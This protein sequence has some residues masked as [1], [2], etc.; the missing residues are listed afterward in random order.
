MSARRRRGFCA[1]FLGERSPLVASHQVFALRNVCRLATTGVAADS[2]G[3]HIVEERVVDGAQWRHLCH[4]V[5]LERCER[6]G[7]VGHRAHVGLEPVLLGL[8]LAPG[9]GTESLFDPVL[10][11]LL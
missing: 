4:S 10:T 3:V 2:I 5:D 8:V 6:V 9:L 11:D 7:D 1:N